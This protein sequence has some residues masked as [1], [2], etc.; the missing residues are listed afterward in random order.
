MILDYC[1]K[2]SIYIESLKYK[3]HVIFVIG[4]YLIKSCSII[5]IVNSLNENTC[6]LGFDN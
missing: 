2:I 5:A 3:R 1:D 6:V 4:K